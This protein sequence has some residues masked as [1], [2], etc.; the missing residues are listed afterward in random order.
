[1]IHPSFIPRV[2]VDRID[3]TLPDLPARLEGWTIAHLTD[4]HINQPRRRHDRIVEI[5]QRENPDLIFLTGDY[6]SWSPDEDAAAPAMQRIVA[7][8]R[9]KR[10]IFGV[11]GNHDNDEIRK[12]TAHLPL[13][14]LGGKAALDIDPALEILGVE[15]DH[16]QQPDHIE[17]LAARR[18]LLP[19]APDTQPARRV[20]LLLAHLPTCLPVAADMGVD[21]MFSGHTHGGQCRLPGKIL[22]TNSTD[23]P[24]RLSSGI[25]RHKDTLC[26]VSRGLGEVRLPLRVCCPPHLP[27]YTLRQGPRPGSFTHAI[28]NAKPW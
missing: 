27:I 22:L 5:I 12:R 8:L 14:W 7:G 24:L 11:Y 23:M 16:A 4:L 10:G 6:M 25:L 19:H 3:L 1:M 21:V 28:V 17:T 18:A 15:T 9:A 26:V 2:A 20:R 13:R